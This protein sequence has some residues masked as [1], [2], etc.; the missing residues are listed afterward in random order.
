VTDQARR[1]AAEQAQPTGLPSPPVLRVDAVTVRLHGARRATHQ[2]GGHRILDEVSLEVHQGQIVGVIGETGSGKTTLART[3]MGLI[4]PVGGRIELDGQEISR[5]RGR[6]RRSLRRSGRMQLVFQD[7]LRSLD[8][9]FTVERIVEEG[10]VIQGA[11]G[12]AERR[13]AAAEALRI[14]GLELAVTRRPGQI[15]GGQRQRVAI[16]R[17]VVMN[18]RLLVCDEPV[19]ALDASTRNYVLRILGEL[20]DRLSLAMVVISHDLASLAGIADRVAVLYQGRIVEEGPIESIFAAPRHPYTALLIASAPSVS[21]ARWSFDI[22]VER[23]RR[24]D[25][26]EDPVGAAGCVF[27]HRCPFVTEQCRHETPPSLE[28]V[29]GWSVSC[30]NS[31]AWRSEVLAIAQTS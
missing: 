28:P 14:V 25:G 16:A 5:L 4:R 29:P 9:D 11:L 23:L 26:G 13:D 18:P 22:P 2:A 30:H 10:L 1:E 8:P 15:S 27:A 17:A 31:D 24:A 3:I 12:A 7:P 20:R 19:S 6:R 21:R